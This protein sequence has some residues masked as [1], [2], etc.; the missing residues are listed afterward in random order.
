M[1]RNWFSRTTPTAE[2]EPQRRAPPMLSPPR[3]RGTR[4][5]QAAETDRLT[6]GWTSTPMPADQIIRR[7]WRVLVARSREQSANNDYAKAFKRSARRNLIGQR[8]FVLQAQ[9]RDG[10]GKLDSGANTALER[11]WIDWCRGRN[12]DV[13]G[14]RSFRQIQK[15]LVNGLCTDGEFM[16]R[17]VYGRDAGPWGFALQVLDP[18]LCPVDFDEDR[19]PGGGFIRAGIEYTKLGRPVA[20]YF[21]TLD[22]SQADY[23]YSGRAFIRVPADEIVHWFEEEFVGQ[24]RGLPWMATALL[25]MRQLGDFEKSAL[26][27]A[28]ES[29]KKFGVIEWAEGYGPADDEDDE[30]SVDGDDELRE[31]EIDSEDG[32][33]QELPMGARLKGTQTAYPNGEMAV[34]SK[35]Q[36]RGIATGLGVAYND[37]AND[38]EGVNLSSIRHGVLSERDHW[39]ELQE[40][41][42]EAF[43]I[44]VY[45][46]WLEVALLRQR[47]TLDN[48]S[49]LP[50]AKR[51]K[52][53]SVM[54]QARRWQWIDPAKDVKADADA[55]ENFF[56]SRGQV[57]RERGRDPREV[58]AEIA[59][60]IEDMRAAKIP[61][62]I[63][64]ALITAKS[65]G[66]QGN[67]QTAN[68]E[69][70]ATGE[71]AD[72]GS[73]NGS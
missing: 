22:Q 42:I 68:P 18:V 73:K 19:R 30:D 9:A 21:T 8:G 70:G 16:V 60:D 38:L 23:H 20:Y 49:A 72:E 39:Q 63:I 12:C 25:R 29:A 33:Y 43:A 10:K 69:A 54:F 52:F 14:R 32:V 65:K 57:I 28:R 7:N 45:E 66:G 5:F 13:R 6:S 62:E 11:A 27:N 50:A 61:E 24:K 2:P 56:K 51:Q 37:L 3:R 58:Y 53:L 64:M 48:G 47:I 55:V 36:L 26:N 15:T 59:G 34:F 31:F 4:M 46:R 1:I 41:L 44:P 71:G 17:L 35:H 40:S 67:G